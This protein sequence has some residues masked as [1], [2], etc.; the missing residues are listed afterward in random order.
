MYK[1]KKILCVIPARGGSKRLPR[2]AIKPMLGKPLIGYAIAAA[3][4]SA[5]LD[6]IVVSTDSEEIA[7]V[8]RQEGVEVILRPAELATDTAKIVPAYQHAVGEAE[9]AGQFDLVVLVQPT[10]PGVEPADIDAAIE[11]I[12]A[13]GVR[14]C[15]SVCEIV[16]RPEFMYRMAGDGMLAPYTEVPTGRTQ[17]MEPLYR[18]NGAVYV[19]EHDTLMKDGQIIDAKSC[20]AVLMPRERSVDIDT[21]FDFAVAEEALRTRKI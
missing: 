2:K 14:S 8:A 16:D 15:I 1:D 20:A 17:D 11:K 21:A 12:V 18:V 9:S 3:K 19:T 5:Y 13:L 10:V 7:A 6:K 4:S